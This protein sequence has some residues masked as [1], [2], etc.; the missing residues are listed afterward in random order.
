MN[1][2]STSVTH[3]ISLLL[4][5]D[6]TEQW[7]LTDMVETLFM[8]FYACPGVTKRSVQHKVSKILVTL[9]G[10]EEKGVGRKKKSYYKDLSGSNIMYP[11]K[12]SL[13]ASYNE[14]GEFV[15]RF[16]S[17][18]K[19]A[20]FR[21]FSCYIHTGMLLKMKCGR[22]LLLEMNVEPSVTNRKEA[23]FIE[24]NEINEVLLRDPGRVII[25]NECLF[26]KETNGVDV[27]AAIYTWAR[28]RGRSVENDLNDF[29][30]DHLVTLFMT[31]VAK[32]TTYTT[33][34]GLGRFTTQFDLEGE[35]SRMDIQDIHKKM[36]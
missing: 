1:D 20:Y 8:D 22:K 10:A 21:S 13:T 26:E 4:V 33:V 31:G 17:G 28:L 6:L 2:L 9:F 32:W 27:L 5:V 11:G 25:D 19:V 30:C 36:P 14:V 12:T 15:T 3:F 24:I 18:S 34:S 35:V 29:N 23:A 7:Y 16:P